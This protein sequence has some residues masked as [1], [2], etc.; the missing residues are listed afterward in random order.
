MVDMF[1]GAGIVGGVGDLKLTL[2]WG[3]YNNNN[4]WGGVGGLILYPRQLTGGGGGITLF[5]DQNLRGQSLVMARGIG[6]K[7]KLT[8]TF[9]K[10][11]FLRP[12]HCEMENA[13]SPLDIARQFFDTHSWCKIFM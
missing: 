9:Y 10:K 1:I 13:H 6:F 2:F 11:I 4:N 5:C 7:R 3:F 12:T 8:M